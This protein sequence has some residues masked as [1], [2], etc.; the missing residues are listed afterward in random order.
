[1][2]SLNLQDFRTTTSNRLRTNKIRSGLVVVSS[3]MWATLNF[4]ILRIKLPLVVN[5]SLLTIL[6]PQ[7][8]AKPQPVFSGFG[9]ITS[10]LLPLLAGC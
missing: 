1:M 3:D 10:R 6:F 2:D 8:A 7:P 9:S 5:Y 4:I